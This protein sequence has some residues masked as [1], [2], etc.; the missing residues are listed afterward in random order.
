MARASGPK[1]RVGSLAAK[2]ITKL[3]LRCDLQ[4]RRGCGR[5]WVVVNVCLRTYE[6]NLIFSSFGV[7]GSA[8]TL[9]GWTLSLTEEMFAIV[10]LQLLRRV[11]QRRVKEKVDNCAKISG[12]PAK[13]SKYRLSDRGVAGNGVGVPSPLVTSDSDTE[14]EKEWIRFIR[15]AV[16]RLAKTKTAKAVTKF[17]FIDHYRRGVLL[18][19]GIN[20]VAV[21]WLERKNTF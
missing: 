16:T 6:L 15:R 20:V 13:W 7:A 4:T 12:C 8:R 10:V 18:P 19:R 2:T 1:A 9:G 3:G 14:W 11:L 5:V 17:E 21:S